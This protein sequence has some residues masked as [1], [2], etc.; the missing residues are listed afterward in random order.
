[1]DYYTIIDVKN[2]KGIQLFIKIKKIYIICQTIQYSCIIIII[3]MDKYQIYIYH[4]KNGIKKTSYLFINKKK[5]D[6]SPQNRLHILLLT[7]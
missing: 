6:F 5:E 1:M 3:L 7:E 2:I 4:M